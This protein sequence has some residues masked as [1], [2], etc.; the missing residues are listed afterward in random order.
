MRLID[1]FSAG[2]AYYP[3]N[4]AFVDGDQSMTFA[5]AHVEVNRFAG[6][7]KALGF[8]KGDKAGVLAPNSIDAFMA[9]LGVFRSQL[10]W[11]PVNP[12][13]SVAVNIDLMDR[14]ECD[15]LMYHSK[16][17]AEAE[18]IKAEVSRIQKLVC[19]DEEHAEYPSILSYSC[20]PEASFEE[21][22]WDMEDVFG[23]FATGGT[24]GKSKGVMV[25]HRAVYTMAANLFAHLS[26]HDNTA[27]LVVAPM[28]HTAGVL[29]CMHFAR[30]GK[31]VIMSEVVPDEILRNVQE[32]DI[33]H[34]F[35]PPT[36]L[37]ALLSQPN[38][39]DFDYSSLQHFI[40]AAAPVSLE[41]LKEATE[42]FGPVMTEIFGQTEAPATILA[43]APWDYINAD[44]SLNEKRLA[45]AG[46]PCVLNRVGIMDDD[47]NLLPKGEA[48]EIVVKGDLVAPGYF[49][50]PE[51]T[52]EIRTFGWHHTGDV[53]I[54]D[55]DGFVTIVDRK[56]D[57]I[58][59]GGFNVFPNEIEQVISGI[60]G[61][62]DCSVIGV[63]D[64]KW[65]EAVKAVVQL[66]PGASVEAETIMATVKD[67]LGS[68]KAPKS[69]D[70]ID[71]M[72][73]S[74]AGKVLKKELRSQYWEGATRGVS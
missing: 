67:K 66:A 34:L 43:K 9:L 21:D 68:V 61:V 35:L 20:D 1:F 42:V 56:K 64:E 14:F 46:R 11:L 6:A 70:F 60:D 3:D 15:V 27:H 16:Y 4:V 13:N 22:D 71:Q 33:T 62:L 57:M 24:T 19:I 52:A 69:V 28:T 54:M 30:G 37:Y 7:I 49:K 74:P 53:G 25:S 58:I 39:K 44:G 23:I 65:G 8:N 2:V 12:R 63:P 41:K 38:V 36:V 10:T 40:V 31:N 73:L 17:R 48:G 32:H 5:E 51:A 55:E 26:Y 18:A 45:S 47:G 72:P 29:G 59:T 50:N